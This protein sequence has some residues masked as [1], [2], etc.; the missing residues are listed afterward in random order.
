MIKE[1]R[2]RKKCG[3]NGCICVY[4]IFLFIDGLINNG[5]V[6]VFDKSSIMLVV[7]VKFEVVYGKVWEENVFVDSGVGIM[8]IR[9][10]FFKGFC[11]WGRIKYIDMDVVGGEWIR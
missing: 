2:W 4:Y 8:V 11:F 3:K 10:E 1:C 7:W 5:L 9:K 6:L